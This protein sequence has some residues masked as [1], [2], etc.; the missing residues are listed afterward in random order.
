MVVTEGPS[1]LWM[2]LWPLEG[3]TT[4]FA[5]NLKLAIA[6]KLKVGV[7][8]SGLIGTSIT[9]LRVS[10]CVQCPLELAEFTSYSYQFERLFKL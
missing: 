4:D 6:K 5:N 8:H 3:T 9:A 7:V 10:P 2:I 1:L